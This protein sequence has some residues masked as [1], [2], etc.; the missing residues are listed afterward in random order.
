[1]RKKSFCLFAVLAMLLCFMSSCDDGVDYDLFGNISGTVIDFDTG[2]PISEALV[3]LTPGGYNTY[4]G[5]DGTFVFLDIEGTTC[6]IRAQKTGYHTNSKDVPLIPGGNQ[7]VVL[8]L[9]RKSE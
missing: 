4:T 8:T 5:F 6:T 3:T 7:N 2:D 9:E 1:M